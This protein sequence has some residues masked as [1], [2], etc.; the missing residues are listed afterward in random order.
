MGLVQYV[1]V[2][3]KGRTPYEY[4]SENVTAK[5]QG[6]RAGPSHPSPA[7]SVGPVDTQSQTSAPGAETRGACCGLS[8][9]QA[10]G[11]FVTVEPLDYRAETGERGDP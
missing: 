2:L 7:P 3:I 9:S 6:E 5:R 11:C 1:W 10:L 4:W 8:A